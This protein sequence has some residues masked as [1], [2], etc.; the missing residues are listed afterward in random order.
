MQPYL[1]DLSKGG[2]KYG[3]VAEQRLHVEFKDGR[4]AGLVN[5]ELIAEVF[6]M[7]RMRDQG[8]PYDLLHQPRGEVEPLKLDAKGL[9]AKYGVSFLPSNQKGKGRKKDLPAYHERRAFLDGYIVVD[10]R[11]SPRFTI[12]GIEA[13]KAPDKGSWTERQW[14]QKLADWQ[15]LGMPQ[16]IA[17]PRTWP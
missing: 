7:T 1:V 16:I 9:N 13:H 5:E 8:A 2:M 14:D 6:G 12:L 11:G 4:I 17:V 10:L 15:L 3:P